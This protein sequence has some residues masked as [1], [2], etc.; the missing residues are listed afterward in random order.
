MK[1]LL[2]KNVHRALD[3]ALVKLPK[4]RDEFVKAVSEMTKE[5]DEN[6]RQITALQESNNLLSERID[7]ANKTIKTLSELC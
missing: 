2:K 7:D 1:F 4:V 3:N 6:T 5:K